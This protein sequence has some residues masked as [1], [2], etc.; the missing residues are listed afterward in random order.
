YEIDFIDVAGSRGNGL[1]R[2][3]AA[4]F[5]I[6]KSIFQARKVFKKRNVDLVLGM[7]GFA[8]GAGGF[9]AWTLGI[10]VVFDEL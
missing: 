10:H 7:G 5:Q 4:T 9:A 3:L 2:L 1:K 6:L 8:S